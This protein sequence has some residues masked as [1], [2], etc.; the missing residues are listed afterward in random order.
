MQGRYKDT[1]KRREYL[2]EY[3]REWHRKNRDSINAKI[4][5]RRAENAEY[6]DFQREKNGQ[7]RRANIEKSR[8]AS[9]NW[10]KNNQGKSS[11]IK[12]RYRLCKLN[13]TPCWLSEADLNKIKRKYDIARS[14]TE[15]TGEVWHVD[16][17]IPLQGKHVSG[18][19][20]PSNLRVVKAKTNLSK[21]NSFDIN[22]EWSLQA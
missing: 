5:K 13:R 1:E 3:A 8:A 17:V 22:R 12:A 7:W 4:R 20:V 19:H 21:N 9:L 14:K 15:T 18:L 11:A 16:H 6:R 2:K 10:H